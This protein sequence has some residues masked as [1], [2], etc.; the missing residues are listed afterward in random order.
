MRWNSLERLPSNNQYNDEA[1][2]VYGGFL[3]FL[4]RVFVDKVSENQ[5]E[6]NTIVKR[7]S[8]HEEEQYV[9]IE[10]IKSNQQQVTYQAKHVICTQYVG[11]LKQSMHQ[12]FI[13]PL[14]HAKR[15]YIQKLVF[16]TINKVC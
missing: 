14:L 1:T 8:I 2:Y 6:L 9:D 16:S 7:V 11:C 4:Q 5:I 13:P 3:N 10:V 12:T 15:M